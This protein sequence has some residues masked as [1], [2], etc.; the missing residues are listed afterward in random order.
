MKQTGQW[1]GG[2]TTNWMEKQKAQSDIGA[3]ER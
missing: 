3:L 2:L 1:K